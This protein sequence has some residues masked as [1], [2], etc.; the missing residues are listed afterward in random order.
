RSGQEEVVRRERRPLMPAPPLPDG[1]RRLHAA[2]GK[3][4]PE[5]VLQRGDVLREGW[6]SGTTFIDNAQARIHQRTKQRPAL[7]LPVDEIQLTSKS[8]RDALRVGRRLCPA[9]GRLPG[10]AGG[11]AA[12][13]Y[14]KHDRDDR[15]SESQPDFFHASTLPRSARRMIKT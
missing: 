10:R 1:P 3:G 5:A 6:A 14:D 4:L 8:N 7:P 15:E 9:R 12:G 11:R 13:H 2:V